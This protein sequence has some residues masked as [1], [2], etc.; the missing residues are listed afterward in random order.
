MP[1][2]FTRLLYITHRIYLQNVN[3]QFNIHYITKLIKV[4]DWVSTKK[5][6]NRNKSQAVIVHVNGQSLST[7]PNTSSGSCCSSSDVLFFALRELG[8]AG[9]AIM[10]LVTMASYG[11][12][13]TTSMGGGWGVGGGSRLQWAGSGSASRRRDTTSSVDI[14]GSLLGDAGCGRGDKPPVCASRQMRLPDIGFS[15]GHK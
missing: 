10:T 8:S 11:G 6:K 1:S 13:G 4:L 15:S 12:G 5:K 2:A 7:Q 9:M 3:L 14:N